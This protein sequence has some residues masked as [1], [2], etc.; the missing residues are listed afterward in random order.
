M[1]EASQ[2]NAMVRHEQPISDEETTLCSKQV[3]KNLLTVTSLQL[4]AKPQ[5]QSLFFLRLPREI[6]DEIYGYV[7]RTNE[8]VMFYFDC[9]S[10]IERKTRI[11]LLSASGKIDTSWIRSCKSFCYEGLEALGRGPISCRWIDLAGAHSTFKPNPLMFNQAM[12]RNLKYCQKYMHTPDHTY[13]HFEEK[14]L[15]AYI[16]IIESVNPTDMFLDATWTQPWMLTDTMAESFTTTVFE[17]PW[18]SSWDG[19]FRKVRICVGVSAR[20]SQEIQVL[21][22]SAENTAQR[23]VGPTGNVCRG[24]IEHIV[25]RRRRDDPSWRVVVL[26]RK[27]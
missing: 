20:F 3:C 12:F 2:P 9:P 5:D 27:M 4:T 15:S 18:N 22:E 7:L 16:D 24:E 6:R 14:K 11:H 10:A 25:S 19:K 8:R 1:A 21:L 26:A 17:R 13:P 23:L